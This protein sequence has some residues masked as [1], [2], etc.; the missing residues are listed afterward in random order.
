MENVGNA[1]EGMLRYR[2]FV[3]SAPVEADLLSAANWSCSNYLSSDSK[4][5]RG[6]FGGW[7]EGNAVVTPG[8]EI[9]DILRVNGPLGRLAAV[10]R[11]SSDGRKTNFNP[12]TDF[13]DFP[14]GSK[15][16]T[17]RHDPQSNR[18]WSLTNYV[19]PADRDLSPAGAR[20]TLALI[21]SPDLHSWTVRC[22]L[23]HHPDTHQ[24][25][26]QYVDWEFEG[27]DLIV[28]SRTAYDDGIG[29]AHNAHDAN[30]LTFHRVKDFR[31]LTR[32]DDLKGL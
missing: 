27:D 3:M 18:Y 6:N 16:F 26:F 23:L 2:A 8:G 12:Q 9:V 20:N 15:K 24:H 25:A 22:V 21:E 7:L 29:G 11:I 17:I 4:W 5:L 31:N 28:A 19:L 10:V 14:G 32:V 13:I 30:F 1:G